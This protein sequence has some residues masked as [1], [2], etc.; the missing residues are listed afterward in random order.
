M[1]SRSLRLGDHFVVDSDMPWNESEEKYWVDS[2]FH[3]AYQYLPGGIGLAS[4]VQKDYNRNPSLHHCTQSLKSI[5]KHDMGVYK[6]TGIFGE[7][8]FINSKFFLDDEP[9]K[10]KV[11]PLPERRFTNIGGK[12]RKSDDDSNNSRLPCHP[13]LREDL[14]LS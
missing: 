11:S 7:D 5:M 10:S 12:G 13:F 3:R 9:S 6:H 8:I 4:I 2:C 1:V 14:N